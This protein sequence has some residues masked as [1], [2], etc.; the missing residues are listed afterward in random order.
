MAESQN[1]FDQDGRYTCVTLEAW[2]LYEAEGDRAEDLQQTHR[3]AKMTPFPA[4]AFEKLP[5]EPG[6]HKDPYE[7]GLD[8]GKLCNHTNTYEGSYS[9]TGTGQTL[10][11][12]AIM[13]EIAR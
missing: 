9:V 5:A 2:L 13:M 8:L 3:A 12:A 7:S 11:A 6:T 10:P 1:T 4:L